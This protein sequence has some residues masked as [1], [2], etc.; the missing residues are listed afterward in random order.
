MVV[1]AS[2]K[3]SGPSDAPAAVS[4]A[5]PPA[6]TPAASAPAPDAVLPAAFKALAGVSAVFGAS[7]LLVPDLLVQLVAA[8]GG[9][10]AAPL[11]AAF[12]RIAG[13]TMAISAAVEWSLAVGAAAPGRPRLC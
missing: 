2:D 13:G 1:R 12:T 5:P 10:G 11:E 9:G 6:A 3:S 7:A 4:T 8:G